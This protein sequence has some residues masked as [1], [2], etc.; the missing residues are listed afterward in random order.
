MS[1]VNEQKEKPKKTEES[2]PGKEQKQQNQK[3]KSKK[4]WCCLGGGCL[5]IILAIVILNSPIL[6][7]LFA[8]SDTP[9]PTPSLTNTFTSQP[10]R[11]AAPETETNYPV[12]NSC[13]PLQLVDAVPLVINANDPGL[14]QD[15]SNYYY[16]VYGYTYYEVGHQLYECGAKTDGLSY[17]A[18]TSWH[19]NWAYNY[20]YTATSCRIKD[21]A[22][23]VKID[24]FYP[25]WEDP[26]N[27]EGGLA[28]RWQTYMSNLI[29]HEE[30]HGQNGLNA[31]QDV[32]YALS[33][34][35]TYAS[36]DELMSGANQ[37]GQNIVADYSARDKQYDEATN[38]GETQGA[39]FP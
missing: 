26:G 2:E 24:Y 11:A 9:I 8:S 34:M 30:G 16:Q 6:R 31:A 17:A 21:V 12:P 27:A 3:P 15:T 39:N 35:P 32:L 36:C 4:T 22:V 18:Y 13:Q 29:T 37:T 25:K 33:T 5:L 10:T 38:H 28:G 23:G 19:V 7:G 14:H 20:N 1:S